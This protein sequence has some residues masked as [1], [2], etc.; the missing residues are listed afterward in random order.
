MLQCRQLCSCCQAEIEPQTLRTAES[1]VC[2]E[3]CKCAEHISLQSEIRTC[4]SQ[5]MMNAYLHQTIADDSYEDRQSPAVII[6]AALM[7]PLSGREATMSL[8]SLALLPSRTSAR[9]TPEGSK[10]LHWMMQSYI[11]LRDLRPS[12]LSKLLSERSMPEAALRSPRVS[13]PKDCSRR[14]TAAANL[15]SPPRLVATSL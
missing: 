11:L 15:F 1:P 14:A 4:K 12:G 10:G 8:T 6:A 13:A 9:V 7:V 2:K 3:A 5:C